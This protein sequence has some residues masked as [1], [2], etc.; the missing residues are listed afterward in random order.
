MANGTN[1]VDF[2]ATLNVKFPEYEVLTPQRRQTF[3]LRSMT[4]SE[5]EV[6][7]G[8]I[9]TPLTVSEH[10]AEVLWQCIIKKPDDI[11]TYEDFLK[12]VTLRDRD[13]LVY[14]LFIATYKNTQG[15]S[16]TCP[17]CNRKN[18][19][20]ID[21]EAGFNFQTWDKDID[22]INFKHTIDLEILS[23]VK[24]VIKAPVIGE[25]ID[26]TKKS[27]QMSEKD[28]SI[29]TDLLMIDHFEFPL[30]ESEK[31]AEPQKKE[32]V[33]VEVKESKDTEKSEDSKTTESP[34]ISNIQEETKDVSKSEPKP[35]ENKNVQVVNDPQQ[36]FEIFKRLPSYDRKLITKSYADE[37]DKYR[38]GVKAVNKC[39]CGNEQEINIDVTRQFFL[40]LY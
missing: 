31:K 16:I 3:S 2:F 37:F 13:C 24:C 35:V 27:A 15:F 28:A 26:V 7:K 14:G 1:N 9:L 6:L 12:K 34:D 40:A 8:S 11:Q 10:L 18:K 30:P 4:V 32:E 25:E 29:M 23:G 5:E 39:L 33:P 22:C 38:I 36:I 19:V 17:K 21:M 20:K